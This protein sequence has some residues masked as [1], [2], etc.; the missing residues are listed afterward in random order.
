M[1]VLDKQIHNVQIHGKYGDCVFFICVCVCVCIPSTRPT[2]QFFFS[3][4][5]LDRRTLALYKYNVRVPVC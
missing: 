2:V 5:A 4:L 1:F 3:F